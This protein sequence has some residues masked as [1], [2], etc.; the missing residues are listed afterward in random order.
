MSLSKIAEERDFEGPEELKLRIINA[1]T[2]MSHEEE[3]EHMIIND[4]NRK[5]S[6][7]F[8]KNSKKIPEGSI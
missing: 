6:R 3:Y 7:R 8:H 5:S 2:E 4:K 1:K